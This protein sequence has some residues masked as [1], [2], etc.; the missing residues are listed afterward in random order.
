[1]TR[2]LFRA[3]ALAAA[4]ALVAGACGNDTDGAGEPTP[5]PRRSSWLPAH[6]EQLTVDDTNAAP[7]IE[8]AL[9]EDRPFQNYVMWDWWPVRDRDGAVAEIGGWQVA[10][11]LTAPDDVLPGKR[12]DLAT[13]R[14]LVSDDQGQTW[15]EGGDVFPEGEGLGSRQWAG[16][17]MYDTAT[18]DVYVFY[19]AAG[20]GDDEPDPRGAGNGAGNADSDGTDEAAG[21]HDTDEA[22]G[23]YVTGDEGVSY[24]QRMVVARGQLEATGDGV[25]FSGWEP[26]QVILEGDG[27][28][29]ASTRDTTGGAGEIDAFRD[30]W[31]FRDPATD[32]EYLLFTATLPDAECDA[33][34][35][36]GIAE[37]DGDDLMSWRLLPPLL[38]A[39]CVNKELERPQVVV[40]DGQYYLL[41]TTHAH[42]FDERLEGPEGLYG[43]VGSD[44]FG[45][46]QPLNGSGLVLANPQEAPYQ[47]YSWMTLPNGFVTS[48][49][50]Y[51]DLDEGVDLQYVGD[52]PEEYQ[53]EKF[54]GTFAPTV[55]IVF[56][57]T[58]TRVVSEH[59][60]GQ[61]SQS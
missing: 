23:D 5:D 24:E 31:F 43:F 1:M 14:Y 25:Q 53:F 27:E 57:G 19:T 44:L 55:E 15:Q 2:T 6:V 38:D 30:P 37:R 7:V 11:G 20:R 56:E 4:L 28:L 45:N 36:V 12:H 41:F 22:A 49:F 33:D 52:Q 51:F 26:H 61:L 42:T 34:G 16:S 17:T 60:P 32:R 50:Q 54:A 13:L 59:A 29:Y 47:A 39:D 8:H 35:V 58:T 40:Q 10:I 9:A 18:G 48:F 3:S 21:D 46:Y